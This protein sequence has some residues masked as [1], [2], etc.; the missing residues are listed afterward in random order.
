MMFTF[1]T[2]FTTVFAPATTYVLRPV[3]AFDFAPLPGPTNLRITSYVHLGASA[4][5]LAV[6]MPPNELN[7]DD[8]R[9]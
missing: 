4:P 6:A 9:L 2:L 8:P 3:C 5:P 1:L 7:D